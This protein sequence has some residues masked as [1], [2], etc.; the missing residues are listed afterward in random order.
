MAGAA[1]VTAASTDNFGRVDH[2]RQ[3]HG[4][5]IVPGLLSAEPARRSAVAAPTQ[6]CLSA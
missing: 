2:Y 5:P 3:P 4:F 6:P 1:V